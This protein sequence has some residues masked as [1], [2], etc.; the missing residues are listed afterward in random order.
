[1]RG[2]NQ[3]SE[4]FPAA[5]GNN[6]VECW[7]PGTGELLWGSEVG[8]ITSQNEPRFSID[9]LLLGALKEM[10]ERI[11]IWDTRQG[12]LRHVL[13]GGPGMKT[14]AFD[15]NNKFLASGSTDGQVRLWNLDTGELMWT[16]PAVGGVIINIA[17][18]VDGDRFITETEAGPAQIWY[19][20]LAEPLDVDL[21]LQAIGLGSSGDDLQQLAGVQI[22]EA[23]QES[24]G[25]V[26]IN[27]GQVK[28]EMLDSVGFH[29][30][31]IKQEQSKPLD[32]EESALNRFDFTMKTR[33]SKP[34]PNSTLEI[35]S[36]ITGEIRKSLKI[37]ESSLKAFAFSPDKKR[38][39][40]A[41]PPIS[42]V[43][44]ADRVMKK[45][46]PGMA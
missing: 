26:P 3:S 39:V 10:E 27:P 16:L 22:V 28:S 34:Q 21:A 45:H 29:H 31:K 24:S 12:R 17:F 14:Y 2:N 30:I 18:H 36:S 43:T 8:R 5:S 1:M 42:Q 11:E 41:Q 4:P 40:I 23:I 46:L 6:V 13:S 37:K 20:T 19:A 33:R 15:P 38:F 7:D 9:G 44:P 35:R 25:F 32:E